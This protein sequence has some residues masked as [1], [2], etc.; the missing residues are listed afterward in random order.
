MK[1]PSL[2]RASLSIAS[3]LALC[4]VSG[5]AVADG[6]QGQF[7]TRMPISAGKVETVSRHQKKA[8]HGG[9]IYRAPTTDA[10]IIGIIIRRNHR[11]TR[12]REKWFGVGSEVTPEA[13]A[14]KISPVNSGNQ[15]DK[16]KLIKR[17]NQSLPSKCMNLHT[18]DRAV[19]LYESQLQ[20]MV[21]LEVSVR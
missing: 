18:H 3:G 4:L 12:R 14:E 13:K 11:A 9:P 20:K 10:E 5:T 17:G 19:C 6:L 8:A 7:K 1:K 2:L 15:A 21:R 16:A